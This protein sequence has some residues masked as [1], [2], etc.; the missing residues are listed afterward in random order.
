MTFKKFVERGT[1]GLN[2]GIKTGIETFDKSF[3]G[4]LP[5]SMYIICGGSGVGKSTLTDSNF[6]LYPYFTTDKNVKFIYFS[7]ELSEIKKKIKWLNYIIA[8]EEGI[9]IPEEVIGGYG[10]RKLTTY[11]LEL[12]DRY[13]PKVE[14]I[15]EDIDFYADPINPTGI[16]AILYE[17]AEKNGKFI[18]DKSK[19]YKDANGK[20][21]YPHE[22]WIPN[23]PNQRTVIIIDHIALA[24][25]EKGATTEKAIIDKIAVYMRWFR[26]M[27]GFTPILIQQFNNALQSINR[28]PRSQEYYTPQ[29]VDMGGSSY[30]FREAEIVIGGINPGVFDIKKYHKYQILDVY[31]V[32]GNLKIKGLGRGASFWFI[33]KNRDFGNHPVAK[34][35]RGDV[36]MMQ[37]LPSPKANGTVFTWQT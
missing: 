33:M 21:Q 20:T 12:I 14:K 10:D 23:D 7:F 30:T 27:C 18:F 11:E 26:N 6:F 32:K 4:I 25:E 35:Y 31:D 24:T 3:F 5:S 28:D 2:E 17:Y 1:K 15:F 19:P 13:L 16:R 22:K 34:L 8:K 9:T 37:E 36:P 29:Q